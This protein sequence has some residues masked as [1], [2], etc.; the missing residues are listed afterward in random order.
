MKFI[1]KIIKI[2][3]KKEELFYV[4]LK[5]LLGFSP[6]NLQYYKKAFIHRSVKKVD[7]KTY[8]KKA[9]FRRTANPVRVTIFEGGHEILYSPA[10]EW[11]GKQKK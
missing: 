4:R 7:D 1:R 6:K 9:L 8:D 3:S 10:F 11:L 2:R 5:R